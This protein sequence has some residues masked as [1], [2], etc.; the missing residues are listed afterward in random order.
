MVGLVFLYFF[1]VNKFF[2]E[3]IY[4]TQNMHEGKPLGPKLLKMTF[5]FRPF[6]KKKTLVSKIRDHAP[7]FWQHQF[8]FSSFLSRILALAPNFVQLGGITILEHL[9]DLKKAFFIQQKC[10][11]GYIQYQI[12]S[13]Q[14]NC[15]YI[16]VCTVRYLFGTGILI[17]NICSSKGLLLNIIPNWFYT[18]SCIIIHLGVPKDRWS[19]PSPTPQFKKILKLHS[20]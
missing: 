8:F 15:D 2:V 19:I 20:C 17:F 12:T 4:W 6:S 1:T 3:D 10:P 7:N 13:K 18:I 14:L 16:P 11:K 9:G 5:R